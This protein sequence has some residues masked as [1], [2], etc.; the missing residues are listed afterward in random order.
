MVFITRSVCTVST[1]LTGHLDRSALTLPGA[2]QR[3]EPTSWAVS[4][5]MAAATPFR[6]ARPSAVAAIAAMHRRASALASANSWRPERQ[7]PVA[8]SGHA[9]GLSA[10][11]ASYSSGP[12]IRNVHLICSVS[13]YQKREGDEGLSCQTAARLEKKEMG[14]GSDG[15][16]GRDG[17]GRDE[18]RWWAQE[19]LPRIVNREKRGAGGNDI[20][21]AVEY[22]Y[23]LADERI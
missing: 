16:G 2:L 22:T 1:K 21:L 7:S 14:G 13:R 17:D 12:M 6:S 4:A 8:A 5:S 9:P 15:W 18:G 3:T 23:Y 20:L 11:A 19:G 10:T